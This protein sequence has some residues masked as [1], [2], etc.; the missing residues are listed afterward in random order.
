[1]ARYI[2]AVTAAEIISE[3]M[4]IHIGDLVDIFAKIPSADVVPKS[5]YD[6][7]EYKLLGVMHSVDKWLDGEELKQDEVNRAVTMREKTLRIVENAKSEVA[8]EIFAEIDK[9]IDKHHS[10][11]YEYEDGDECDTAIT[12][13]SYVSVDIDELKKKYTEGGAG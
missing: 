11:C 4:G 3:E 9:I 8:R 6:N 7:L 2:D 10:Q 5:N 12:Y 13:L 1:M